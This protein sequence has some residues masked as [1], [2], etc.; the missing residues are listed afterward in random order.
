MIRRNNNNNK[1][2]KEQTI[3]E[4][5]TSFQSLLGEILYDYYRQDWKETEEEQEKEGKF[6][7]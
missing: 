1:R 7:E 2:E 4:W 6:C 5:M 3:K